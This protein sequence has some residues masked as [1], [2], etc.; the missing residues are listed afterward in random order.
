MYISQPKARGLGV[1]LN[2]NSLTYSTNIQ[3][4]Y[5]FTQVGF[6]LALRW[7]G[8]FLSTLLGS[9]VMQPA[10]NEIKLAALSLSVRKREGKVKPVDVA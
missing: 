4:N 2:S 7:P 10:V 6:F 5:L 8:F 3:S 1:S 9:R